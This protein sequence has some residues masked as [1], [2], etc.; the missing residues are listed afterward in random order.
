MSDELATNVE[1]TTLVDANATIR[2]QRAQILALSAA[3]A[4]SEFKRAALQADADRALAASL[5]ELRSLPRPSIR[6]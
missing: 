6:T 1:A 3:L 2:E 5:P 4:T